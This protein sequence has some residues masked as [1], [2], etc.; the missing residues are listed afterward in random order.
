MITV[1]RQ[2]NGVKPIIHNKCVIINIAIA[3][4]YANYR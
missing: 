3:R 1:S 2:L 4:A